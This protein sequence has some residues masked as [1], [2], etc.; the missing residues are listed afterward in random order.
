MFFVA[1]GAAWQFGFKLYTVDVEMEKFLKGL[2][3]KLPYVAT[4]SQCMYNVHWRGI[5]EG[6][7]MEMDVSLMWP[8]LNQQVSIIYF[9]LHRAQSY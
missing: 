8:M 9:I 6:K 7:K 2:D 4:T 3:G 5:E 1:R